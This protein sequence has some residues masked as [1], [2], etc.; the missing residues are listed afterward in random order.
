MIRRSVT[1]VLDDPRP[2]EYCNVLVTRYYPMSLRLS[3]IKFVDSP[4]DSWDRDLAPSRELLRAY[5]DGHIDEKGYREWFLREVPPETI[6][7]RIRIH[8]ENAG[9]REV[10]LACIEPDNEFC[11]TWIL[12]QLSTRARLRAPQNSSRIQND[13]RENSKGHLI[14][15]R[16]LSEK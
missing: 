3:R 13:Q 10:V 15:Y 6:R 2:S 11:H 4:F 7:S 9:G 5:K 8:R 16:E 12:L 14:A 1:A